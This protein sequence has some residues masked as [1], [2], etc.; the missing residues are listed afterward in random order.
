[1]GASQKYGEAY[2]KQ[3]KEATPPELC[4]VCGSEM[5]VDPESG[6]THC[7]VCENPDQ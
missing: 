3:R 6:E 1:M 5:E 7:P 2:R 4:E